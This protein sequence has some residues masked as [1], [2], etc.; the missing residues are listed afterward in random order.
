MAKLIDIEGEVRSLAE[1][2]LGTLLIDRLG[3]VKDKTREGM[4]PLVEALLAQGLDLLY[5]VYHELAAFV[6]KGDQIG[7]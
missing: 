1:A 6:A 3:E 2:L 7:E 4:K 5:L